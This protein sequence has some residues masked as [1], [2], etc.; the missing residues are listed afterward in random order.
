MEKIDLSKI[1]RFEIDLKNGVL[2]ADDAEDHQRMME[3]LEMLHR[4]QPMQ[5]AQSLP[6]VVSTVNKGLK[7]Q[8]LLDKFFLLKS[9]LKPATVIG[10]KGTIEEFKQF[11]K[12]PYI[13]N[14]GISDIT[15]YQ[16]HLAG[17]VKNTPRTIDSKTSTIRTMF[18]YAIKQGY[19]F[20]KNPA[21]DRALLT[22]KEKPRNGW[23]IAEK[24]EIKLLF[25][26]EKFK[27]LKEKDPDFY[28]CCVIAIVTGCRISEITSLAKKQFKTTEEKINYISIIDSKTIAGVRDIP[29]PK[30]IWD[31]GLSKIV[32]GSTD[33]IFK[34]KDRLGKGSGN[35]VGKKFKRLLEETKIYRDKLVFHSLRKFVNDFLGKN[36]IPIEIR[37]QFIGHEFDHVNITHYSKIYS[38][39]EMKEQVGSA[40]M[41]IMMLTG[42]LPTKF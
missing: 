37:C 38:V 19:Y 18:N 16:E 34:Y 36:K 42:L 6:T 9:K 23:A 21:E 13:Q 12:N 2:K 24:E 7:L 27:E 35:A 25:N 11:L 32:D 29:I 41:K 1:R 17:V 8:D 22:K 3:A 4:V 31:G 39:A 15:R 26:S 20:D 28:W 5:Q 10:Y 30:Y 40:Q 14:I 33:R